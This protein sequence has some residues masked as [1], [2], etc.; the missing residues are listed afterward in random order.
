MEH[1]TLLQTLWKMSWQVAA[2][3]VAVW[4][5]TRLVR[6]APANW[7]YALW[8][9]V[10]VKFFVPPFAYF[11]SEWA[12]WQDPGRAG[13]PHQARI[14]VTGETMP[15]YAA[16]VP[17]VGIS[18][19]AETSTARTAQ[20]KLPE[21]PVVLALLWTSGVCVMA[22]ILIVR[23]VRQRR[24]V[25]TS[26]SADAEMGDLSR[27]C[28]SSLNIRRLPEIRF[29]DQAAIPMVVGLFRPTILL[30]A[31]ITE[32]CTPTD[33]SAILTHE[34]A[35]V[36]RRDMAFVWLHQLAQALFFFHPAVWLAGRELR[37][38]RELA[39]D[40]LVIGTSAVS[41]EDYASGYVSALKL[42]NRPPLTSSALAMA[43]PLVVEKRR[44]DAILR[45][46]IPKMSA[47]WIVALLIALGVGLPTFAGISSKLLA[48]VTPAELADVPEAPGDYAEMGE[49]KPPPTDPQ[50]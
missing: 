19:D 17:G 24:L 22:M 2:A 18:S 39:C 21:L 14:G 26:A 12:F 44:L 32:S 9:I 25:R 31:Q 36:K 33:L 6:R 41:R 30:P 7:R 49:L 4:L 20:I 3:A 35:H 34:L 10:L 15:G 38:E 8:V 16:P 48:E 1:T 37:R 40:E 43:E 50:E 28:A 11:P 46:A 47:R 42:A 23:R 13:P 5:I 45:S 27:Q 29:S